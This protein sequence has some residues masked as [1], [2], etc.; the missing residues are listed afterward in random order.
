VSRKVKVK[1]RGNGHPEKGAPNEGD[2]L[3]L[4]GK[5]REKEAEGK[6]KRHK[7]RNN[8]SASD[9]GERMEEKEEC[10]VVGKYLEK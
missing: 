8:I 4:K 1:R 2:A 5:K 9:R 10:R 6:E 7:T 3:R